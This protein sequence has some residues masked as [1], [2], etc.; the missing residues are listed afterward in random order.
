MEGV[1]LCRTL[2][3]GIYVYPFRPLNVTLENC[4]QILPFSSVYPYIFQQ[5]ILFGISFVLKEVNKQ[6][7][8]KEV[9]LLFGYFKRV[10][11]QGY[12]QPF[13]VICMLKSLLKVPLPTHKMLLFRVVKIIIPN[14]FHQG[15]PTKII[16]LVIFAGME[17]KLLGWPN[18][19]KF[20]S[21]S[22]LTSYL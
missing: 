17:L 3:L 14:K 21:M 12:W 7:T 15:T 10:L 16:F 13:K 8:Q 1:Y 19:F 4:F 18:F 20:H 22:M 5:K 2:F 9:C 6:P 11:S